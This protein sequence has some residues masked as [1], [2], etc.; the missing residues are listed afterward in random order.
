MNF[1]RIQLSTLYESAMIWPLSAKRTHIELHAIALNE[2]VAVDM[3]AVAIKLRGKLQPSING[4]LNTYLDRSL[5][6]ADRLPDHSLSSERNTVRHSPMQRSQLAVQ[7]EKQRQLRQLCLN[8]T[9][10]STY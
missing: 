10:V 4:M 2:N 5:V 9:N 1:T 6:L 7:P 8:G 3:M